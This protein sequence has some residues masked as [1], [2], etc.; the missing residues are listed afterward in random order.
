MC[1]VVDVNHDGVDEILWGERCIEIQFG[2]QLFCA[3]ETTYCGHS[4]IIMSTL[5]F[6]CHYADA[7][8]TGFAMDMSHFF[9]DVRQKLKLSF[10]IDALFII[11]VVVDEIT[12][13]NVSYESGVYALQN[14]MLR[15]ND[16]SP[17]NAQRCLEVKSTTKPCDYSLAME[18]QLIKFAQEKKYNSIHGYHYPAFHRFYRIDITFSYSVFH[19][20]RFHNELFRYYQEAFEP[21]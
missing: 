11:G 16:D 3:D 7:G 21:L 20:R 17:V 13:L 15:S 10:H 18:M 14:H 4:D 5:V 9:T 6:I 1:P 19:H 12:S 2:K 8:N